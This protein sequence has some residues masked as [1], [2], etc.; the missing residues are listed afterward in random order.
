[1][2][3][4]QSHKETKVSSDSVIQNSL[5]KGKKVTIDS[6]LDH[7]KQ[8]GIG[9]DVVIDTGSLGKALGKGLKVALADQRE[10]IIVFID[11]LD[12]D[13]EMLDN[14]QYDLGYEQALKDI[15][16]FI[17]NDLLK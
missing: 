2:R 17:E 8:I 7:D 6:I 12:K 10:E 1:M 14:I 9:G 15:K 13:I 3:K 11:E 5:E 4:E 16:R